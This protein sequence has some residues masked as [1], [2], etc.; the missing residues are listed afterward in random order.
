MVVDHGAPSHRPLVV[1]R[2]HVPVPHAFAPG[3]GTPLYYYMT[4][5]VHSP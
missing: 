3:F 2:A 4:G 5:Y 1:A